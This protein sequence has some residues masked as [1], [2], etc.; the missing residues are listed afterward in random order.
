MATIG[1]CGLLSTTTQGQ[2]PL[3]FQA[4]TCPAPGFGSTWTVLKRDGANREVEPY[5]SSLG[6]GEAGTG[7]VTSPPFVITVD[8]ITFTLRGHDGPSGGRGENYIALVDARKGNT[9][10][11]TAAPGS[12]DLQ[13]LSWDVSRLKKVEVRIEVHDGNAAA[14][15]AWLGVGR[16]DAGPTFTVNFRKGMPKA[17]DRPARA[18]TVRY[19]LLTGGVPFRRDA[20]VFTL[21]PLDGAVEIPCGFNAE[22]LYVLGCTVRNGKVGTT[23]GRIEIHYAGGSPDT[24]ELTCG[25]TLDGWHKRLSPSPTLHVHPSSDPFQHYLVIKPRD[26]KIEKI[27]MLANPDTDLIPRI[28]AVTCETSEES[29]RLTPL[30]ASKLSAEEA[31]W[32]KAHQR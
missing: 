30:P 4:L 15:F 13:T 21:I 27:R 17:W 19:E 5:L 29:D 14:G 1:L 18:G 24:I 26:A 12:D 16:I 8:T 3:E 9:L 7:S 6:K 10:M 20:N 25:V 2:A 28:T 23:Y 11:K 32:I 31:A 22:R